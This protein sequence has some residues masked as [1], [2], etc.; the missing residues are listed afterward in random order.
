MLIT[1][2]NLLQ[3]VFDVFLTFL[4]SYDMKH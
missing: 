1:D 4:S 3:D 2:I